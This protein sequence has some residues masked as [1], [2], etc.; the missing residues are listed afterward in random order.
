MFNKRKNYNLIFWVHLILIL[1][2]LFSPLLFSWQYIII[3][4]ILL[5]IEY[6]LLG[7]CILTQ[8]QFGK[9][10]KNMTF[11][12]HIFLLLNKNVDKEKLKFFVRNILPI[13][14]LIISLLLQIILNYN[15]L[16]F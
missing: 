7:N 6:Y 10:D 12:Y 1:I 3:G 4:I 2:A 13:I 11:W 15:P 9:N 8:K 14:L 16:L 5:W